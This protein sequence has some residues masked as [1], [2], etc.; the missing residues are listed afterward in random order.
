MTKPSSKVDTIDKSA[1]YRHRIIA[2]VTAAIVKA[3]ITEASDG[4]KTAA[5]QTGEFVDALITIMA[6]M[7]A[8]SPSV[9]NP[10]ALGRFCEEFAERLYR[11]TRAA[12][13]DPALKSTF[14]DVVAVDP[15]MAS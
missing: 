8:T 9:S 11:R 12:Q 10:A 3:S 4:Y 2:E 6:T 1:A 13:Q 15:S 14:P 5:L 7:M